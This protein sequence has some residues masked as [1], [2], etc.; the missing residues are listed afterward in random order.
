[1][2]QPR[3]RDDWLKVWMGVAVA[4][5]GRSSCSRSQVGAV[6]VWR[7]EQVFVGYNGPKSGEANCDIGGCP[8]G[9]LTSEQL[10]HGARFDGAIVCTAIHAEINAL[11]KFK[12]WH[13]A[14][15]QLGVHKVLEDCIL[16][17]TREPCEMC[18]AELLNWLTPEQVVWS[19]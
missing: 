17:S 14:M 3:E 8:R 11:I 6:L 19:K 9:L 10:P 2:L 15:S 7:N 13:R 1:M 16:Y 5:G 18:W 4:I 12:I